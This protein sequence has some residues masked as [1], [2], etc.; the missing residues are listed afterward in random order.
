MLKKTESHY[1]QFT[2]SVLNEAGTSEDPLLHDFNNL[3]LVLNTERMYLRV[4]ICELEERQIAESIKQIGERVYG[5]IIDYL[6]R[7]I[8][9]SLF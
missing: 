4:H 1:D 7:T 3:S 5:R 8:C 9:R 6:N 2:A